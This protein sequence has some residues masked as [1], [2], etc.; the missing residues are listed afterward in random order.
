MNK[1]INLQFFR[2]A[3]SA[4]C[5]GETPRRADAPAFVADVRTGLAAAAAAFCSARHS[6]PRR[7]QPHGHIPVAGVGFQW[8]NGRSQIERRL[9]TGQRS[10]LHQSVRVQ[11]SGNFTRFP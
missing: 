8:Q 2:L 5:A 1:S 7:C 9:R 4:L 10:L 3:G 11:T 6:V